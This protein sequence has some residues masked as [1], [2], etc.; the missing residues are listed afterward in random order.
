[1]KKRVSVFA[2]AAAVVIAAVCIM[3]A[4][5][6]AKK[7]TVYVI[8]SITVKNTSDRTLDTI[9]YS[10]NKKGMV[11]KRI[12]KQPGGSSTNKY[13][14]DKDLNLV[15]DT[16]YEGRKKGSVVSYK[17]EDGKLVSASANY[18]AMKVKENLTYEYDKNGRLKCYDG[19]NTPEMTLKYDKKGLLTKVSALYNYPG[20]KP[21]VTKYKYDSKGNVI[22]HYEFGGLFRIYKNKYSGKRL[23]SVT[24]CYKSG[25]KICTDHIK[26]K[27]LKVDKKYVPAIKAQQVP[28]FRDPVF[29]MFPF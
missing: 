8:R 25:K 20:A 11:V 28:A 10:Y 29:S 22:K 15:K 24:A 21:E 3:P 9:S 6:E 1:M 2:A 17:Y 16:G 5:A 7:K 26:Y 12:W 18:I 13:S 23:D 27:K 4:N 14:Y 19:D